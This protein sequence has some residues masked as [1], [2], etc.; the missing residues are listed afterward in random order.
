MCSVYNNNDD[1][2]NNDNDKM[3]LSAS[4]KTDGISCF[5][6]EFKAPG[7]KTPSVMMINGALYHIY[8]CRYTHCGL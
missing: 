1:D 4:S 8:D 5:I 7:F 2:D 6:F 3:K